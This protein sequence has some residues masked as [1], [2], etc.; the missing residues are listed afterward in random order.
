MTAKEQ[1]I[2]AQQASEEAHQIHIS[3]RIAERLFPKINPAIFSD[4]LRRK[5]KLSQY[6]NGILKFYFTFVAMENMVLKFDG[7]YYSRKKRHLEVAVR[8][9]FEEI[10]AANQTETIHLME[11]AFLEG[12]DLIAT[13]KLAAP[14]DHQAFKKDVEAIF[15]QENWYEEDLK[16]YR[17]MP[18]LGY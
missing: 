1:L 5:I 7:I 18:S 17:A 9:P 10:L 6:D 11:K 12:I 14:F 4:V 16:K 8:I 13:K 3:C 15:A 2:K